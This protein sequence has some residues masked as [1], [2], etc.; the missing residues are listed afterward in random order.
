MPLEVLLTGFPRVVV[1]DTTVNSICYG[2]KLMVPGLLRFENNINVGD[3]I[4]MMTTK[5]EAI[6]VGIA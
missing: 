5:G 6:A 2:A 3:E 1:K 4:V